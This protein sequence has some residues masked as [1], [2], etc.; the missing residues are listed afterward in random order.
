MSL[1]SV[2]NSLFYKAEKSFQKLDKF[3]SS[4]SGMETLLC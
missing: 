2:H 4:G 1:D 3:L